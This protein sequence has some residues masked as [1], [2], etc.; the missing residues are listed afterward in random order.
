MKD[1]EN[2]CERCIYIGLRNLRNICHHQFGESIR[3][4][5]NVT[6]MSIRLDLVPA[7]DDRLAV[8]GGG[9]A[10]DVAGQEFLQYVCVR[11]E[12]CCRNSVGAGLHQSKTGP[13]Q[14][15]SAEGSSTCCGPDL[16]CDLYTKSPSCQQHYYS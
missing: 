1:L 11:C 16:S 12:A 15:D 8:G 10:C 2:N 14:R 9:G 4:V 5:R 3:Q 6:C 7:F 13:V